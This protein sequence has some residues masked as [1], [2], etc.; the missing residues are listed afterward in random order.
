MSLEPGEGEKQIFLLSDDEVKEKCL[1][2][3]K[4]ALLDKA[5]DGYLTLRGPRGKAAVRGYRSGAADGDRAVRGHSK[6]VKKV[7]GSAPAEELEALVKPIS[8]WRY[9]PT[10]SWTSWLQ[11]VVA[12]VVVGAAIFGLTETLLN[13]EASTFLRYGGFGFGVLAA[14]AAFFAAAANALTIKCK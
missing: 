13:S 12:L 2:F 9:L 4:G 1:Q 3:P 5:V 14:A 7:N 6:L 8:W 10:A 11:V